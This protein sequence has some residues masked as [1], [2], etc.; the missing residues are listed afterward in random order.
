MKEEPRYRAS[1]PRSEKDDWEAII[2]QTRQIGLE[3]AKSLLSE[4]AARQSDLEAECE[5]VGI[6][7]NDVSHYWYKS[8]R[9]SIFAKNKVLTYEQVR[10][11]LIQEMKAHAPV[12]STILREKLDDPHLLIFDPADIH[13]GKLASAFETNETY[14]IDTA[15]KRVIQ[16]LQN[17]VRKAIPYNIEKIVVVGG[18]DALHIDTPRRTTTSG[19]PQDTDGMWYDGFR[20][21]KQLYIRVIETL[22]PLADVHF[23]YCPS[24]HDYQ[25]GFFLADAIAS[26]FSNAKN[27]TFDVSI[28]HRKYLLYGRSLVGFTHGDGA[29]H[30]DLPDLMK[31]EAKAAWAQA[32]FGYW[33]AHHIHHK[34]RSAN[35]GKKKDLIEK[36]YMDVSVITS[37]PN[38]NPEDKV[39]VE[40]LRTPS[41]TD[42]WHHRNGYQHAPKAVEAFVH[43]PHFGQVSRLVHLF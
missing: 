14:N 27:V 31:T 24:N 18:N 5:E 43:H 36:D 15:E 4:A 8:K 10:D 37:N 38:V 13:I 9:F 7:P 19:T 29:K 20:R 33:Y 28:A 1:L 17:I 23:V 42:S 16:G 11:E 34:D 21:A 32:R 22:L 41:G 12:Y 40:Y 6:D 30:A 35:R 3:N 2:Q 25:S 26:W 39:F